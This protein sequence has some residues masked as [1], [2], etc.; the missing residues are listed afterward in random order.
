MQK[1]IAKRVDL[2]LHRPDLL[3]SVMKISWFVLD[4]M[5]AIQPLYKIRMNV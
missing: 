3:R 4:K 1:A 2:P 5:H